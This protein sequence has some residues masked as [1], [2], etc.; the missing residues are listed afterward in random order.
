M[1][2]DNGNSGKSVETQLD[3]VEGFLT[4]PTN[5]LDADQYAADDIDGVTESLFGSGNMAYGVLQSS[6]VDIALMNNDPSSVINS[7]EYDGGNIYKAKTNFSN[8]DPDESGNPTYGYG[9][10][11]P[12]DSVRSNGVSDN[13][14]EAEGDNGNGNFATNTVGSVSASQ[15]SSNAD[16]LDGTGGNGNNGNNGGDGKDGTDGSGDKAVC[17]NCCSDV[18]FDLGDLIINFGDLNFGDLI[19]GDLNI[20][21]GD[22]L[23]ILDGLVIDLSD[24]ISVLVNGVTN[25]TNILADVVIHLGDLDLSNVT[26]LVTNLTNNL[27]ETLNNALIEVSNITGDITN[28]LD[29]DLD[30]VN[31]LTDTISDFTGL[32]ILSDIL[33]ELGG[34]IESLQDTTSQLI[35]T[36]SSLDLGD[37]DGAAELNRVE[38]DR[39]G[40]PVVRLGPY[41]LDVERAAAFEEVITWQSRGNHVAITWSPR[42][43]HVVITWQ[44]RG[45]RIVITWQSRGNHL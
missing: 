21:L 7:N 9:D 22:S 5:K 20:D 28:I 23:E 43:N 45:N 35:N 13:Y 12:T 8:S 32:D 29:L 34:S 1:V 25:V 6:L 4:I 39:L 30:L 17:G 27:T 16:G 11:A 37:L 40:D 24:T 36:V 26:D 31:N 19:L 14:N 15:L 38:P 42:G 3:I 10:D 41:R 33:A 18:N 2:Y 44:S